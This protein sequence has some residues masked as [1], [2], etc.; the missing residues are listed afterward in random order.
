[1]ACR[2]AVRRFP[3]LRF[4]IRCAIGS[5]PITLFAILA[6]EPRFPGTELTLNWIGATGVALAS[7]LWLVLPVSFVTMYALARPL[8]QELGEPGEL[9]L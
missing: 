3:R 7:A 9:G 1:M 8:V 2:R 6:V 5:A 4:A